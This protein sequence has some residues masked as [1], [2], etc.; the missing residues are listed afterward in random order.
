MTPI[1]KQ[2]FFDN[3]EQLEAK[4][5]ETGE[6]LRKLRIGIGLRM[7]LDLPLNKAARF[8]IEGRVPHNPHNPHNR[9]ALL[10]CTATLTARDLD[11]TPIARVPLK[12]IPSEF[13]PT[14]L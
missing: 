6:L 5:R 8:S 2:A 1:E 11:G 14:G 7:S 9:R 12:D 13:W 10:S 4:H 3:I